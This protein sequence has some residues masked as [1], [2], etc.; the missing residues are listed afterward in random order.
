MT[1][2][3]QGSQNRAMNLKLTCPCCQ[4]PVW[5][6]AVL[7]GCRGNTSNHRLQLIKLMPMKAEQLNHQSLEV[8]A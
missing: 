5:M 7:T 2:A 6:S 8:A 3:E 4:A 1:G